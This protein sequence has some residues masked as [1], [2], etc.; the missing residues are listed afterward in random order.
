M[1]LEQ[2]VFANPLSHFSHHTRIEE[3]AVTVNLSVYTT[4]SAAKSG[5]IGFAKT[6]YLQKHL[7]WR[8]TRIEFQIMINE[9]RDSPSL[10]FAVAQSSRRD[11]TIN[12]NNSKKYE[13]NYSLTDVLSAF[14]ITNN[15]NDNNEISTDNDNL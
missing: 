10:Q 6:L 13:M 15:N 14:N 7:E 8:N 12:L 9:K 5:Q 4:S 2:S 3:R 11:N 1:P